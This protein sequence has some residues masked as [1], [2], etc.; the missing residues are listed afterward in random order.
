MKKLQA[1]L[2]TFI[3][4]IIFFAC[5]DDFIDIKPTSPTDEFIGELKT[6]EL[7]AETENFHINDTVLCYM[8]APDDSQISRKCHVS[9]SD[10]KTIVNFE[11]GLA[12][13]T[14]RLLYFEYEITSNDNKITMQYGLGCRIKIYKNH[15]QLLDSF[16]KTMQMTGSGTEDDPYIVTCGPHLYNLTLGVK[17]FYEYDK[18]NGAY[19]KQVADI[20][21]HDASY[22]CKHENGWTPIG[23]VAYPF[24]G[25]YDGDGHIISNMY[26]HHNEICGVGLFGHITNSSIQNLTIAN[27]D[28]SGPVGVG[29]IA[30]CLMSL[31]GERTTSSI[32]NC[33]VINSKIKTTSN[34][35]GAGG[36]VGIIDMHT[37][38][39]IE[40]C[41]SKDNTIDADYNA[42]GI[43]GSSSAYSL[44]SID[45]CEN[46]SIVTTNYA[47]AGGIIGV[48][49]TLS[50]TTSI[51]SGAICGAIKYSG[52]NPNSI[53]RGVGGICGGSGISWIS[54]C[55]NKAEVSGYEGVGGI[56]GTTRLA[57]SEENGALYNNTYLRYC[58]NSGKISC[59]NSHIGGLCGE[60]QL[61]CF[62]S[63]NTGD[64]SGN[65][66]VGGIA[67]HTSLS[68]IHN[69]INKGKI[70]GEN[71][72][73]GISAISNSGV[74]A[75][76][77]NYGKITAYGSHAAGIVSL[78]GNNTMIHYCGNYNQVSGTSSPVGGI[79][80]AFG[81]PREWSSINIAEV[82]FGCAE[83]CVSFLGPTFAI[84][85]HA[86]NIGETTKYV[87]KCIELGVELIM[88]IPSTTLWGYGVDHLANPHHI[89]TL[90]S[91]IKAKLSLC[92][93]NY[94]AEIND[95]RT[96]HSYSS[97]T[98][99]SSQPLYNQSQNIVNLSNHLTTLSDGDEVNNDYF[100]NKLN[101]R[102]QERAE[103]IHENNKNKE[104]VYT[105]FGAASIVATTACAIGAFVATGGLATGFIVF[106][107]I[108]GV[109]GGIN[110]I[111]K[112]AADYTD[113]VIIISQCVNAN[114]IECFN[115]S[116][117][118]AGGLVGR[119]YDRG[120]M[121]DCL[122]TGYFPSKG[123]NFIGHADNEVVVSNC[124]TL[125]NDTYSV[126]INK[127]GATCKFN[128]L[129][130]YSTDDYNE[131][132]G[133]MLS[134]SEVGNPNSYNN[135][136]IGNSSETWTI[137]TLS[138][139]YSF[140]VPFTSEMTK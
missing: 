23:D 16:D 72:I 54:G 14:Y 49:D 60:A 9:K 134:A 69:T 139:G 5:E 2:L 105:V 123:G 34:G 137:P 77:Q 21:L 82:V 112:G 140:P 114:S 120:M 30:G 65:D 96:N 67:G 85:E 53:G 15:V 22:Y 46:S 61:G 20:S 48:A 26:S 41:K 95:I 43:I 106:G 25:I 13:G 47:G 124:L 4:C 121:Y 92:I 75:N 70:E 64:V 55:E 110:S 50:I 90:E 116:D 107:T 68:V 122:N 98:P 89:E 113:N 11:E 36:I 125:T 33:N 84:A 39:L 130:F 117:S 127:S 74:Y 10:G 132:L 91:S 17:D 136:N 66:H 108:S 97:T 119:M 3:C 6:I 56:I 128:N 19:F 73:A 118:E 138:S 71:Y 24:V 35:I 38:G 31:S 76:C 80:G 63:L 51:N 18:F 81:N 99:F 103:D 115:V 8:L 1:T 7:Y 28:I 83:I 93:N 12:D 58:K 45:L 133:T 135:W 129:Y 104:I 62:G 42:G 102:M 52:E 100:N 29:G 59:K 101:N 131:P 57:Y 32:I 87:L 37:V 79:V 86:L 109:V 78:S 40:N 111:S 44:T 88:K 126:L 27:A 94:L